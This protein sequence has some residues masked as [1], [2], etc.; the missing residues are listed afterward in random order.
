MLPL[1]R[2]YF[3]T[4]VARTGE[5]WERFWFTPSEALTLGIVRVATG[6]V[7]LYWLVT[8]SPDLRAFFGPQGLLTADAVAAWARQSPHSSPGFPTLDRFSYLTYVSNGT[9]LFVLHVLALAAVAAFTLGL[10]ARAAAVVS[11]VVV[12]S[13]MHR[14][15]VVV[16]L[17]E[18]LLAMVL[19]YLCLGPCGGAL[20]LDELLAGWRAGRL[21]GGVD[22]AEPVRTA[23]ATIVTRLLQ[24]HL[25][26]FCF[27]MAMAQL[28]GGAAGPWWTGEA[29][30]MIASRPEMPL[31]NFT[32][33]AGH[34]YLIDVWTRSIVGYE[35]LFPF[36]IWNR[37]ARPVVLVL[38]LPIWGGLALLTGLTPFC[39]M[40]L[41]ASLA[42]VP[43]ETIRQLWST[44]RLSRPGPVAVAETSCAV[45]TPHDDRGAPS[46]SAPREKVRQTGK[47]PRQG[48]RPRV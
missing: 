15:P 31:V 20:S 2:D 45:E 40:M 16:S 35:L 37:L 14:A 21:A 36:L 8:W 42:F 38:G 22:G 4:T 25:A 7:T 18:P 24:I 3:R 46:A 29:V 23:S 5:A 27:M 28:A 33:L 11:L 19:F 39:V 12:L 34:P 43:P 6:L 13:Y 30:W 9:I 17:V 26:L 10:R 44:I 32:W 47:P 48:Q 41:V 1:I